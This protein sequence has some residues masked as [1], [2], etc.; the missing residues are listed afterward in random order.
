VTAFIAD[1][2]QRQ[3]AEAALG[4]L[5]TKGRAP[6]MCV[7]GALQDPRKEVVKWRDL[8]PTRIALRLVEDSQVDMV[9]G[10]GARKRGA[11]CDEISE[12]APGVGYVVEDGSKAVTRVRAGYLTDDDIRTLAQTFRPGPILHAVERSAA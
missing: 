11:R 12:A 5:L 7:V 8:F 10:D 1:N 9:L 2:K 4:R 3:R 6:G